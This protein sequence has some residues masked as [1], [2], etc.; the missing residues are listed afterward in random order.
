ME[1]EF[2]PKFVSRIELDR[3]KASHEPSEVQTLNFQLKTKPTELRVMDRTVRS[4]G[5]NRR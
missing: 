3:M 4:K 5:A 1:S 2:N